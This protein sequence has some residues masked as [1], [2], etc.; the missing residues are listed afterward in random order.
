LIV[1]TQ[2]AFPSRIEHI[3]RIFARCTVADG[4]NQHTPRSRP[5]ELRDLRNFVGVSRF[6]LNQSVS[7]ASH[8][9]SWLERAPEERSQ[10]AAWKTPN[11][12][13]DIGSIS[14]TANLRYIKFPESNR[15]SMQDITIKPLSL[16]Q[17]NRDRRDVS[18]ARN[19][20]GNPRP[21]CPRGRRSHL[22]SCGLPS[23]SPPTSPRTRSST[24]AARL[25]AAHTAGAGVPR[26]MLFAL[27]HLLHSA[28]KI[29]LTG[30]AEAAAFAFFSKTPGCHLFSLTI[31]ADHPFWNATRFR[32]NLPALSL[33]GH[34]LPCGCDTTIGGEV[35]E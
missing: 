5:W 33:P 8:T 18:D 12:T 31:P 20:A 28:H 21:G 7:P 1:R 15:T 34:P 10:A 9:S 4:L 11:D 19:L 25:R 29:C 6:W 3:S 24:G 23:P 2:R 16:A 14:E 17:R 13:L 32:Y 22:D 35:N 26:S 27:A 30:R